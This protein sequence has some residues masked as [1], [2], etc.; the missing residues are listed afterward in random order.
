[1][2]WIKWRRLFVQ[3]DSRLQRSE[4]RV[5]LGMNPNDYECKPSLA[6][7]YYESEIAKLTHAENA[8][9]NE[10][11][12]NG[13]GDWHFLIPCFSKKYIGSDISTPTNSLQRQQYWAPW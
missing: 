8:T 3:N 1:V 6:K 2:Q 9:L 11:V 5:P 7:A 10:L 12:D 4:N 13:V